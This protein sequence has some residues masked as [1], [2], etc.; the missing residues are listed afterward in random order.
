MPEITGAHPPACGRPFGG[1]VARPALASVCAPVDGLVPALR[2]KSDLSRSRS[3]GESSTPLE[4]GGGVFTGSQWNLRTDSVSSRWLVSPCRSR[5]QASAS[6]RN[7]TRLQKAVCSSGEL[8]RSPQ[9][10]T[11]NRRRRARRSADFRGKL[12]AEESRGLARSCQSYLT[13]LR[14]ARHDSGSVGRARHAGT[15]SPGNRAEGTP[16]GRETNPGSAIR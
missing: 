7:F 12:V 3:P 6:R 16:G 14:V 2:Q 15:F 1:A 8:R 5:V 9:A 10:C 4:R 11:D 13:R